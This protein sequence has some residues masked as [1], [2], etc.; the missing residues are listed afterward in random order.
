MN[1]HEQQGL[2]P[3]HDALASTLLRALLLLAA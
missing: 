3:N 2:G 1:R